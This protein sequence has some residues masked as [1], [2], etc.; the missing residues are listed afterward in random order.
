MTVIRT[1]RFMLGIGLMTLLLALV[2]T[3]KI[4]GGHEK[5]VARQGILDLA[6]MEWTSL[7]VIPLDGEWEFYP[8]QLL[9]PQQIHSTHNKPVMMQVPGNW[10]DERNSHGYPMKGKS[11]GTYRLIV[12]N[13]PQD[14]MLAIAKRY[15]R[16]AD[17]MYVDGKLMSRSGQPG[18][19][20][21][22]YVPR[23]EPYTIYFHPERTEIEVVLQVANFDFRSGGIYN[24]M[25]LGAGSH[26]EARTIIQSGLE[27]LII[28]VVVI[29]GLL[30][31]YLYVRLHRDGN[32]LLYA[33]FFIGF[34]LTVV[35]NGERLLLQLLPDIPFELAYKLKYIS[36]Y[37]VS[38]IVSMITWRLTPDLAPVLKRWLQVPSMVLTV[39][40][41]FIALAPFR[42]YSYIQESMYAINLCA[43]AVAFMVIIHQYVRARYGNR[44]RSQAQLLIICIWLML[45]NYVLGIIVTW[46]PISQ[47][48]LNCTTLVILC[49]FAMLLIY[50][51]TQAYASMQQ[52]THQLQLSDKAKDEFLLLTSHELNS[53]LHSIIHLSR[54]LLT[55]SLRRTN[56]SEIRGKLQLIRNTAYRMSNLVNDLIDISRFRDGSIK[57]S[58]GSVDLVSCLS[59]VTEVLGFLASGKSI[60]MIRRLEPEARYVMADESRLLQ[61]LYNLVYHMMGQHHNGKLVLA[62]ERHLDHVRIILRMEADSDRSTGHSQ[63][64]DPGLQQADELAAGVAVAAE[65]VGAMRG[66]LV[67]NDE[68]AS[69][70]IELPCAASTNMENLAEIA[71][72]QE[73]DGKEEKKVGSVI[74]AHVLIATSD[75]VDMEQLN[76]LLTTEGFHLSF[77]DSDVK[78]RTAL[79][80]GKLP[81]LVIVD[82][83]LPEVTGYELCKQVRMEFSQVDLPIL[84]INMRSTPADIEACIQAGGNDF[85]TRPLDAGEIL[86]RIHTLLGMKQ[87]VKEAA[88][89]EMAFLRSQIKPHFLYN[90]LGTIMSL[91]FTDGPR[92]G[93]LLGSFSRYLRILFHLDNTEEL[94]P[95]SKEM[96]LI[97]AYVEIE[98]ER[99][100]S[101]LQVKLDVDSSLSSCKV[102]PLLIEPLVEN[103]IRHGV[104]KKI[105]GGTVHLFIRRYED[106]VQVVV[107]D[108][109]VG[110]SGKQ[111]AFMMNRSHAEQGIGLQNVQRRLKHMN[112]QAPVIESEQGVGTKVTIRFPYQY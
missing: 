3:W 30:F 102:M 81:D 56:E 53:P 73:T 34:A 52:L 91:C 25:D 59:L 94:I 106:S 97:R 104:S 29:F 79:A 19:S 110:M 17:A 103:A 83:M 39:Y 26:M 105:D 89:N 13:V 88:N 41:A 61:V 85:I 33:L 111:V 32:Q 44:R 31:L 46:Y 49:V 28:G 90:A 60:V 16:F 95:L 36:V 24:S 7:S 45:V 71:A 96:E 58:M 98:Q 93:E 87:L 86:V 75:L 9:S 6:G 70:M 100:G 4:S 23:N 48:L 14:E 84:F 1:D 108:D 63:G 21:T 11:Y 101:R 2:V 74:S 43:Y 50:Q 62:C 78:V 51:Y 40:L 72:T 77:A 112:G 57:L 109:G 20:A 47:V 65:M 22:S 38:V 92:A 10:D 82:A 12:R 76:T 8:E 80:G 18:T 35:T 42:V 37:G 54:S 64:A 67:M 69:I 55:T 66:K 68:A 5:P 15:V 107:E 27:L 99:F